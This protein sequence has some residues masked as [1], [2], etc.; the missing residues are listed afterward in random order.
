M[1]R[2]EPGP[3]A[4]QLAA[5]IAAGETSSRDVVEAHL[6]RIAASNSELNAIVTLDAGGARAAADRAD[7]AVA[8][9]EPLG[10]LHGVPITVKDTFETAGL[11]TTSGSRRL[12]GYIPTGDATA[13][14][15]LRT[16]GA[17]VLGKTNTPEFATGAETRNALFGLTNNPWDPT[18]TTG[19][20]SG[21]SAAAVTVG[22]SPLDIGSDI[23]G[24]IRAPAHFCGVFGL[25]PTDNLVSPI[26]HIPPP[27]GS[28][29]GLLRAL[30]S[31]GPLARSVE[32]LSLALELISGPDPARP[33]V[34]P[35]RV[36]PEAPPPIGSLRVA[37]WDDFGVPI[38]SET[39]RVLAETVALLHA[40][41]ASTERAAP[42]GF[43]PVQLAALS[44]EIET[45]MTRFS[46]TPLHLPRF[47]LRGAAR[48]VATSDRAAAGF[49]RGMGGSL[50][51]FARAMS[52]RDHAIR[53][54]EEFLATRD[55]WLVPVA[56]T[57]AFPHLPG[58]GVL[59]QLRS[60]LDVDG[61][62]VPLVLALE[63]FT[64]PFNLTGSPVVVI[65]AGRGPD[66][67]PIG[68]QIVGRRWADMRLLAA[69]RAIS[70]H[71]AGYERA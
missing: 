26:G 13:V 29:W 31:V 42:E 1:K 33:D 3:G 23:G 25:K 46:A 55:A 49:F 60:T 12:A 47:V 64:S 53:Q 57:A 71:D 2:I 40:G 10:R 28:P 8:R 69:A 15:R 36:V 41:G 70:S 34:P 32:D 19:G 38:S 5:A 43:D 48:M 21:G 50:G 51:S 9:G 39:R 58:G 11:R 22:F 66:G 61:M 65:P 6:R 59:A 54:L 20:S 37:W 18:R 16:A 44:S 4:G 45:T 56:P 35:I 30:L 52:L 14:G 27:P 17:I 68:L 7:A 63:A 62:R 24:S 67:L